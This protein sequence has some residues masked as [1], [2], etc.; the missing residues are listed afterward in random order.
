[1]DL[2]SPG[3]KSFYMKLSAIILV[4]TAILYSCTVPKKNIT[5]VKITQI[6]PTFNSKGAIKSIDTNAVYIYYYKNMEIWKLNYYLQVYIAG[7][8]PIPPGF[9]DHIFIFEKGNNWGYD[10]DN[11]ISGTGTRK[12]LDSVFRYEWTVQNNFY[13]VF[14]GTNETRLISSRQGNTSGMIRETYALK[15]MADTNHKGSISLEYYKPYNNIPYSFARELDS[16][17]K[18]KLVKIHL[19]NEAMKINDS[20]SIG[21]FETFY[22]MQRLDAINEKEVM[23]YVRKY[24][25]L[26]DGM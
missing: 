19:V 12:L 7:A 13:Q 17:K 10:F 20:F 2:I 16:I 6:L 23:E 24:E 15:D 1:M 14:N 25:A 9:K 21:R 18:M 22:Q 4:F 5:G 26:R 8:E 3:F 11:R